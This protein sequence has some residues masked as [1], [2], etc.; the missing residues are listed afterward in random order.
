MVWL[1][2]IFAIAPRGGS[3]PKD[4]EVQLLKSENEQL[5]EQLISVG[6]DYAHEDDVVRAGGFTWFHQLTVETYS[7]GG[8]WK[9]VSNALKN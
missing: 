7:R 4:R 6:I 2:S 5:Q 9:I 3:M 1:K 8:C